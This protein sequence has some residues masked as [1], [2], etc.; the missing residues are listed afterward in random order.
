M[1]EG[2]KLS[3]HT[4]FPFLWLN[5]FKAQ[6]QQLRVCIQ[7]HRGWNSYRWIWKC[8]GRRPAWDWIKTWQQHYNENVLAARGQLGF[9]ISDS[10]LV[11]RRNGEEL[12]FSFHSPGCR[13]SGVLTCSACVSCCLGLL[14][15]VHRY[16]V[17][18]FPPVFVHFECSM[19]FCRCSR[20][21]GVLSLACV[22][23]FQWVI[24]LLIFSLMIVVVLD[25]ILSCL[26]ALSLPFLTFAG[27]YRLR[28]SGG[29]EDGLWIQEAVWSGSA[30]SAA[31]LS[32]ER[33]GHGSG[34]WNCHTHIY[35]WDHQPG[36]VELYLM[37][38]GDY[39]GNTR[40]DPLFYAVIL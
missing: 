33:S 16:R 38:S 36:K 1:G 17:L 4:W 14:K 5:E 39:V 13:M 37:S 20:D 27:S 2:K 8:E 31:A 29:P 7:N 23:R 34:E 26:L 19:C 15:Q 6:S 12:V 25:V 22:K 32:V 9:A 3:L 18:A 11:T 40:L 28:A 21:P 35:V 10:S 24:N 30:G